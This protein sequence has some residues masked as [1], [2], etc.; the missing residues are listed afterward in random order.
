MELFPSAFLY[1]FALKILKQ[2]DLMHAYINV[3]SLSGMELTPRSVCM[4]L[5]PMAMSNDNNAWESRN[6]MQWL[7]AP[8]TPFTNLSKSARWFE[9]QTFV[10]LGLRPE[11]H[12]P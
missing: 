4:G 5:Q 2:F 1:L 3:S 11:L 8:P 10:Q 6:L 9:L 12:F 7:S